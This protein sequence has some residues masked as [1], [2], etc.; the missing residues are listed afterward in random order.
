MEWRCWVTVHIVEVGVD[1][2]RMKG[3]EGCG[4][5]SLVRSSGGV[6]V[7]GESIDGEVICINVGLLH[8][9]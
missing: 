6:S 7:V 4:G 9:C 8:C 5:R 2:V 3:G 1:F